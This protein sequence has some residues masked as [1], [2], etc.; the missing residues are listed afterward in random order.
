MSVTEMNTTNG[1]LV[2][3]FPIQI[4]LKKYAT[5]VAMIFRPDGLHRANFLLEGDD[6]NNWGNDDNY[7]RNYICSKE[8]YLGSPV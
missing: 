5:F 6:Y 7:I 2:H 3:I 8:T 1:F 4:I